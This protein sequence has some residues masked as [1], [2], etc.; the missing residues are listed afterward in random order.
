MS[1]AQYPKSRRKIHFYVEICIWIIIIE[2]VFIVSKLNL[3]EMG[4]A[5]KAIHG[6]HADNAAGALAT[7]IYQSSTFAFDT[8][9][10]G[11]RRFDRLV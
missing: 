1:P 7:P 6:G 2:E 9:E 3:K 11:G 8:A 10:Q 5:T 4:F